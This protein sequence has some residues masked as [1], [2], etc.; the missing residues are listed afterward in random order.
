MVSTGLPGP[1]APAR[2]AEI[3]LSG[4]RSVKMV[5]ELAG[6]LAPDEQPVR[7]VGRVAVQ[8]ADMLPGWGAAAPAGQQVVRG[9]VGRD[10]VARSTASSARSTGGRSS[11]KLTTCSA[12]A[13]SL[14]GCGGITSV[15]RTVLA[16]A[17]R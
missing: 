6:P 9:R 8:E 7:A 15:T 12:M 4:L 11:S 1:P 5:V 13:S 3:D 10:Q 16:R 14:A 2:G 17:A